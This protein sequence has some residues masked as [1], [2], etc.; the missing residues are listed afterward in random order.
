MTDPLAGTLEQ[1]VEKWRE[2]Q[3]WLRRRAY[4]V[5]PGDP[6]FEAAYFEVA[7]CADQ[8]AA[9]LAETQEKPIGLRH[10]QGMAIAKALRG[11][12]FQVGKRSI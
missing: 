1:L 10:D 4:S 8:L 7:R 9:A 12:L 5:T 2:Q 11:E 6:V 3:E